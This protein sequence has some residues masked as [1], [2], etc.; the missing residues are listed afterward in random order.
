MLGVWYLQL[1]TQTKQHELEDCERRQT[2]VAK[3]YVGMELSCIADC[4]DSRGCCLCWSCD[5]TVV[6]HRVQGASRLLACLQDTF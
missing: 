5:A 4:Q 1:P 2:L 6:L 3:A